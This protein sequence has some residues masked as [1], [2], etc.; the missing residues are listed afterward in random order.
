[1]NKERLKKSNKNITPTL[2]KETQKLKMWGKKI[3]IY[4]LSTHKRRPFLIKIQ[5]TIV[6]IYL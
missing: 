5:S 1:M 6:Q 4:F 2:T 3:Y